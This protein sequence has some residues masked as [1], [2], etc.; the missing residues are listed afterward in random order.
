MP[1]KI[2]SESIVP[3]L[4]KTDNEII[5]HKEM[6]LIFFLLG[7]PWWKIEWYS[8]TEGKE[9]KNVSWNYSLHIWNS[10]VLYKNL[11]L[12]FTF[13]ENTSTFW[14]LKSIGWDNNL[15]AIHLLRNKINRITLTFKSFSIDEKRDFSKFRKISLQIFPASKN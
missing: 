13:Q 14:T 3:V 7:T 12:Y 9:S 4:T 2:D 5:F 11:Y 15:F 8:V 10:Q 1:I 6:E